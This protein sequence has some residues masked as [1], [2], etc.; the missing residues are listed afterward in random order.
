MGSILRQLEEQ[1]GIEVLKGSNHARIAQ[2]KE[3]IEV[4]K[5]PADPTGWGAV[6]T[7]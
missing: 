2:L 5:R 7:V 1:Y 6:L 3:A 4:I